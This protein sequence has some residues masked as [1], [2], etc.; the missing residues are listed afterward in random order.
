[1]GPGTDSAL[2]FSTV[3]G[4]TIFLSTNPILASR[5][6]SVFTSQRSVPQL[7][8]V[9]FREIRDGTTVAMRA[10]HTAIR[11]RPTKTAIRGDCF[12]SRVSGDA[13]QQRVLIQ[14]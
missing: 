11:V 8:S 10:T 6:E 3:V 2:K 14:L 5:S 1:M 7:V 9:A 12:I 13:L 4:T